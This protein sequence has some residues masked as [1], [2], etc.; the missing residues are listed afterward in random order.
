ML[1]AE[2]T[3]VTWV[4]LRPLFVLMVHNTRLESYVSKQ[5]QLQ[6]G[7]N[8]TPTNV[9]L[10]FMHHASMEP[11]RS[12]L[13]SWEARSTDKR[14]GAGRAA[15]QAKAGTH[16]G[17]TDTTRS[18]RQR[19][20]LLAYIA[21]HELPHYSAAQLY[22]RQSKSHT[23]IASTLRAAESA[24]KA[25][26]AAVPERKLTHLQQTHT[27]GPCRARLPVKPPAAHAHKAPQLA[28]AGTKVAK[29]RGTGRSSAD[30]AGRAKAARAAKA[31]ERP[32]QAGKAVVPTA[33]QKRKQRT[34][35]VQALAKRQALPVEQRRAEAEARTAE[36]RAAVQ[37][38]CREVA[39][40]EE[41]EGAAARAE[42]QQLKAQLNAWEAQNQRK[43]KPS[44]LRLDPELR[45]MY[46]R[47]RDLCDSLAGPSPV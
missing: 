42:H 36:S 37:R 27:A 10:M 32:S 31:E 19:Q 35:E 15:V 1:R 17:L 12:T 4:K 29:Q 30:I 26:A 25:V 9:N 5:K 28:E 39:A 16:K 38:V 23:S 3:P 6:Q 18:K 43:L 46:H 21:K 8:T 34:E 40:E 14:Y 20:T 44:D 41:R 7:H 45:V 13:S 2:R 11:M 22:S 47:Y 24:D 33:Y